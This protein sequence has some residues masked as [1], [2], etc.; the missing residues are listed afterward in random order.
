MLSTQRNESMN[1]AIKRRIRHYR[2]TN[3]VRV[4]SIVS[5]YIDKTYFEVIFDIIFLIFLAN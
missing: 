2:R 5:D 4:I 3:I 1:R